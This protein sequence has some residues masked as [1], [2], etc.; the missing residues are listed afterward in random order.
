MA[1]LAW[2]TATEKYLSTGCGFWKVISERNDDYAMM[3]ASTEFH[4]ARES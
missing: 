2:C 3:Y 4:N 1:H